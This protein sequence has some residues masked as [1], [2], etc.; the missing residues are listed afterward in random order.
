MIL[1]QSHIY[2]DRLLNQVLDPGM[3][4]ILVSVLHVLSKVNYIVSGIV[5]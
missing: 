4:S 3:L 1:N 2:F 5:Y